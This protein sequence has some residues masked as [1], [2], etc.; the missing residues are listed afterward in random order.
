MREYYLPAFEKCIREGKAESIMTAYNAINGV[1][2]TANNW[3]LNKVL[4]QDW[5][6]NGYIVSDCGAPGLLM[7]DHRYVKTP[8]AAAMIAIKAG[9]DLECGDYVFELHY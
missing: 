1:P 3:L 6:F 2:C 8:E 9:L 4:K 7:T 5:G